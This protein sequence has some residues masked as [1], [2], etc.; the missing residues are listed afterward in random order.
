MSKLTQVPINSL[1]D[2]EFADHRDVEGTWAGRNPLILGVGGGRVPK[3]TGA[4]SR[5]CAR[6]G[7]SCCTGMVFQL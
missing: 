1:E 3:G 5:P 6:Q 7:E 2:P 4:N